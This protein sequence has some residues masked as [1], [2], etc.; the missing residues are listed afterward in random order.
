M[1]YDPDE[2][3]EKPDRQT[4]ESGRC[5]GGEGLHSSVDANERRRIHQ[6]LFAD[7]EYRVRPRR[8]RSK[9]YSLSFPLIMALFAVT[10]GLFL[11]TAAKSGTYIT[12][13]SEITDTIM[14]AV[15][16]KADLRAVRNLYENRELSERSLKQL[17]AN[18]KEY[19]S[20]DVPL[21]KI[22]E[23]LRTGIF[24]SDS[25]NSTLVAALTDLIAEH[26]ERNP[27]DVLEPNQKDY[28]ESIRAMSS[29]HYFAIQADVDKIAG[30]L[31]AKNALVGKY[32][33]R[34]NTSFW[35]SIIALAISTMIGIYQI[36]QNRPSRLAPALATMLS[37]WRND[38]DLEDKNG[39]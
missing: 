36:Y 14:K 34:S 16:N 2:R 11:I 38:D 23:D 18:E 30:E 31:A 28:F 24:L 1:T 5:D 21:S 37:N 8:I 39:E 32:L 6:E 35:I 20:E 10:S 9:L 15:A 27:F 29:D 17:F 3:L 7:L 33:N 25:A 12:K 13:K 22:L 19:Y 4:N 26:E